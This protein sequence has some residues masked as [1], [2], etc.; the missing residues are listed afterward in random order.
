MAY[1]K[2]K[3]ICLFKLCPYQMPAPRKSIKSRK[4]F[5]NSFECEPLESDDLKHLKKNERTE[6]DIY[7]MDNGKQSKVKNQE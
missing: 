5:E 6:I 3:C 7:D 1:K 2:K 4:K